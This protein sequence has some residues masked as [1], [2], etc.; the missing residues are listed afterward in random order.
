LIITVLAM[1]WHI[2]ASGC[3]V[4]ASIAT[5]ESTSLVFGWILWCASV[6]TCMEFIDDVVELV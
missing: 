3:T 4:R 2:Y 5:D 1:A 6:V